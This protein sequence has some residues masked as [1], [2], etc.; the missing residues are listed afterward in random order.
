MLGSVKAVTVWQVEARLCQERPVPLR[1]GSYGESVRG[2]VQRGEVR[3]G[4]SRQL[5]HVEPR[6]VKLLWVRAC[7]G[8]E[9]VGR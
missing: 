4:V 1:L 6:L 8:A 3:L 7:P 2:M 9:G 5:R